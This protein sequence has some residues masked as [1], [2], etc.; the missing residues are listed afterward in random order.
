MLRALK[1]EV[2][3]DSKIQRIFDQ[4]MNDFDKVGAK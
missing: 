4:A 1:K 3:T 2:S